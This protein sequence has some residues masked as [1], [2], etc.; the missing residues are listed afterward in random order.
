LR[1]II[2]ETHWVYLRLAS[3]YSEIIWS[4]LLVWDVQ[5][6]ANASWVLLREN[7]LSCLVVTSAWNH[8]FPE[9]SHTDRDRFRLITQ[10]SLIQHCL[11]HDILMVDHPLMPTVE[12]G[13]LLSQS[14]TPLPTP[15]ITSRTSSP[16]EPL[17]TIT[18]RPASPPS[19][20]CGTSGIC[21][22]SCQLSAATES[23]KLT[24]Y[25]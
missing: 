11:V 1:C 8:C 24:Q 10:W 17:C 12:I 22:I 16:S 6:T 15:R 18:G 21:P 9:Q 3:V 4:E 13:R 23:R 20:T 25:G 19:L 14:Q 5:P 7:W 2:H